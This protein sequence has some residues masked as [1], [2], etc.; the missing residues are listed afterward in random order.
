MKLLEGYL[1]RCKCP[2][3]NFRMPPFKSSGLVTT[4]GSLHELM[5]LRGPPDGCV[6]KCLPVDRNKL[7]NYERSIV[8]YLQCMDHLHPTE[9]AL[10]LQ[11]LLMQIWN[12]QYAVAAD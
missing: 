8:K 1:L 12:N 4:D 2:S 9:V 3:C 10:K 6:G 5:H 11:F 7:E